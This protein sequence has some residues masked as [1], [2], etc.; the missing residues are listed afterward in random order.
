MFFILS[1]LLKFFLMPMAWIF[2]ALLIAAVFSKKR[3][4]FIWIAFALFFIF[5]NQA[6]FQLAVKWYEPQETELSFVQEKYDVAIILGG[7]TEYTAPNKPVNFS[8]AVD[9]M[10]SILPI[11]EQGKVDKL[12]FSGGSGS[13]LDTLITEAALSINFLKSLGY[14]DTVLL[15]EPNSRNTYENA[16]FTKAALDSLYG[17]EA[18]FLL[19]TSCIHMPRAKACFDK[20]GLKVDTFCSDPLVSTRNKG[21]D[22]YLLPNAA[23]LRHWEQ[24]INEWFGYIIY[25]AKGYI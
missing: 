12:L 16:K 19:S 24:L 17:E 20:Q 22:F 25:K 11:L 18:R 21:V 14:P 5:S 7:F 3:K 1:K 2:I 4:Q 13:L 9:R 10:T 23:T 8:S 15:A 6:I